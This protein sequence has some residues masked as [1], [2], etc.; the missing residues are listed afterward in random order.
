MDESK[1]EDIRN[2]LWDHWDEGTMDDGRY[3]AI[4]DELEREWA[5]SG[6]AKYRAV[7]AEARVV[8]VNGLLRLA[9]R[10]ALD[11][12]RKST[13]R[14]AL[15]ALY[16]AR[17]CARL[18]FHQRAARSLPR[19]IK[20]LLAIR[21]EDFLLRR[22]L[23]E[24]LLEAWRV[25]E[26]EIEIEAARG[27]AGKY[28]FFLDFYLGEAMFMRGDREAAFATWERSVREEP[29]S[30]IRHILRGQAYAAFGLYREAETSFER[31]HSLQPKPRRLDAL[32][33]LAA[34]REARDDLSGAAEALESAA[35]V[36][37]EDWSDDDVSAEVRRYREYAHRLRERTGL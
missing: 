21:P 11:A 9:A 36:L 19:E 8:R 1:F 2:F 31:A 12:L 28:E 32:I 22:A 15:Y 37:E 30:P 3:V 18:D 33:A 20:A 10:E 5:S 14:D 27:V 7:S 17:N 13:D 34:V 35:Q 6:D 24:C 23:I 4:V 25:D 16:R 29:R 26:A